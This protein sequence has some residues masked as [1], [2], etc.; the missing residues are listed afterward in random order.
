MSTPHIFTFSQVQDSIEKIAK[1]AKEADLLITAER[2]ASEEEL[3]RKTSQKYKGYHVWFTR[4]E[5]AVAFEESTGFLRVWGWDFKP[6]FFVVDE[7]IFE[8]STEGIEEGEGEL[9]LALNALKDR[10][11]TCAWKQLQLLP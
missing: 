4:D 11:Y 8:A 10:N 2:D 1:E 6:E 3:C 7:E 5:C 9:E